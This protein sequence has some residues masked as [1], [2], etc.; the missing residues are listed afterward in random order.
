MSHG[1]KKQID[2]ASGQSEL[3]LSEQNSILETNI[4]TNPK[5]NPS[6]MELIRK[7]LGHYLSSHPIN[8]YKKELTDMN[9]KNIS[10][11]SKIITTNSQEKVNTTISGVIIDSRSQKIGKN[12]FINIF[13][14]DDGNGHINIS[15]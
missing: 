12:K 8:K 4:N 5:Y 14:V 3:F 13:K 10:E 2:L 1:L 6:N 9:L 15:F 11:I 7:R